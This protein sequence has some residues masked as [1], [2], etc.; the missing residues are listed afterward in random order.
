[1]KEKWEQIVMGF[2]NLGQRL[3]TIRWNTNVPIPGFTIVFRFLYMG[4]LAFVLVFPLTTLFHWSA[5]MQYNDQLRQ[6]A[7]QT[8]RNGINN[9]PNSQIAAAEQQLSFYEEKVSHEYFTMQLFKKASTFPEFKLVS[10]LVCALLFL[11]H[12][13]LFILMRNKDFSY[14][15]SLNTH[16]KS[17]IENNY[18]QLEAEA[19]IELAKFKAFSSKYDLSFL[20]K[21]NPY[22][23]QVSKIK[24][25]NI[26]W[27]ELQVRITQSN[28]ITSSSTQ[29]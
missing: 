11:P 19:K 28:Q 2:K 18:A 22:L 12:A 6:E 9:L 20:N 16:F 1:L 10:I 26:S 17:L 15:A 21:G 8:Y 23:E 13:L 4:L 29:V 5:T 27:K 3:K 25:E 24:R 7:L 14:V